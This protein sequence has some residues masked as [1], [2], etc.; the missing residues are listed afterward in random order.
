MIQIRFQMSGFVLMSLGALLLAD[1]DRVLL[2][3]LL[4]PA[5]I[6]PEQPIFYYLSF[7]IVGL[8]FFIAI[9]GLLGCWA[10]CL[11]NCC[12]TTSVSYDLIKLICNID[13]SIF[14]GPVKIKIT[15]KV[16]S[17]IHNHDYTFLEYY[18]STGG[19]FEYISIVRLKMQAYHFNIFSES[20]I[21]TRFSDQKHLKSLENFALNNPILIIFMNVS[22]NIQL[23][24]QRFFSTKS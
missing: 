1:S 2:S 14:N 6:H 4:G 21:N 13:I 10:T 7:V 20:T 16:N 9:T 18:Y 19:Q 24:S 12:I 22:I 15:R 5:D 8:G 3:R 17:Q 11:F 23:E